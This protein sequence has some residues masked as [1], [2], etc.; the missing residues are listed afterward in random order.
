MG[1]NKMFQRLEPPLQDW[2]VENLSLVLTLTNAW[3]PGNNRFDAQRSWSYVIGPSIH[4]LT[5]ITPSFN[6][7]AVD[8]GEPRFSVPRVV[9]RLCVRIPS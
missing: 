9:A 5:V 7:R 1:E 4:C 2:L 8:S 3:N 6:L